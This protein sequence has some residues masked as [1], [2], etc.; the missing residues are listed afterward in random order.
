MF[1]GRGDEERAYDAVKLVHSE[2]LRK[3]D[4]FPRCQ[5]FVG[6]TYGQYRTEAYELERRR[7]TVAGLIKAMRELAELDTDELVEWSDV[8]EVP[9]GAFRRTVRL[10]LPE[11]PRPGGSVESSAGRINGGQLEVEARWRRR[12]IHLTYRDAARRVN[13]ERIEELRHR[14]DAMSDLERQTIEEVTTSRYA[15]P[16]LF[17]SHRWEHEDHPDPSGSQLQKLRALNDCFIIYDYTSFPQPPRSDQAEADFKQI[18]D[19]MDQFVRNVVVIETPDYLTRGWCVYEYIVASLR[20]STVCDEVQD[21][22]FVT[23]RDWA[24]TAPPVALSFRDSFESQQQNFINERVL[25]AVREVVQI[26]E[27]ARFKND[28]DREVVTGLLV[29]HLKRTLPPMKESQQYFGEWKTTSWSDERL[30]A[31]LSGEGELPRLEAGIGIKK[32][33]TA[34]PATLQD[35]VERRYEI[36]SYDVSAL[37]NP[38]DSLFR[39]IRSR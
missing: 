17:I 15:Q 6:I 39:F 28:Y 29:D 30:S 38:M 2:D 12:W 8:V 33:D 1:L 21:R 34:V 14:L 7:R 26:Y 10:P 24:S 13:A 22:R 23:L 35:S 37:L 5:E 31:V 25:E 16:V 4:R 19:S 11:A 36:K 18:L 9:R 27:Q 32:F 20:R 3:W